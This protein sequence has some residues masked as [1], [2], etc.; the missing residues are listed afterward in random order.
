M[1]EQTDERADRDAVKKYLQ[2]YHTAKNQKRILENRHRELGRELADP[3][4][5]SAFKSMPTSKTKKTEGAVSVIYRIAEVE[6]RIEQQR[7]E[8]A[9]AVLHVMD[10][11]DLL[12]PNSMERQ[13]VELRYI[14]CK[15]WDKI[16]GEVHMSRSSVFE[17]HNAALEKIAGNKR[18]Q[19][20]VAE[21]A[22]KY[23]W[24][25]R[26]PME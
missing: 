24:S 15:G 19:K 10:L 7:Q 20:L 14:D 9:K 3:T 4:L 16:S 1:K 23:R 26:T 21:Y 11:V 8:V 18:A 12:L 6:T 22:E 5:G 25:V 2:Q 17:H 13:V